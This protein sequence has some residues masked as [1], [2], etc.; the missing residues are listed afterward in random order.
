MFRLVDVNTIAIQSIEADVQPIAPLTISLATAAANRRPMMMGNHY[1]VETY[2]LAASLTH[3]TQRL[4]PL[5]LVAA[6]MCSL[7]M[8]VALLPGVT[9]M[10]GGHQLP[11]V[12]SKGASSCLKMVVHS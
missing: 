9:M 1:P 2:R 8:V 12:V 4:E 3:L 10:P 11:V 7:W 6:L 5:E